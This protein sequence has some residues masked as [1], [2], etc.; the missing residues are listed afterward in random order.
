MTADPIAHPT[1]EDRTT[2]LI[3]FGAFEI[4]GGLGVLLMVA[5]LFFAATMASSLA[6]ETPGAPAAPFSPGMLLALTVIY[7]A[8][9]SVQI[10][11][12]VGSILCRRWARTLSLLL[13]WVG[14]ATGCFATIAMLMLWPQMKQS[15]TGATADAGAPE[16]SGLIL[17]VPLAFVVLLMV[18]APAAFVLFYRR[19]DVRATC[20]RKDP[21]PRW[22]DSRPLPILALT[23]MLAWGVLTPLNLLMSGGAFILFGVLFRG[24][25]ALLVAIAIAA[26]CIWCARRIW[27]LDVRGWW[28]ALAVW[29]GLGVSG[30]LSLRADNQRL[31]FEEMGLPPEQIEL[32]AEHGLPTNAMAPLMALSVLAFL[33]FFLYSKQFFAVPAETSD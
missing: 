7:L 22:T 23:L 25:S 5:F 29:L 31:L 4:L 12:G 33:I 32:I 26:A 10:S 21:K 2:G 15:M 16:I 9:A 6:P 3:V 14:L 13:A 30:I 17:L 20:E 24:V 18:L 28:T 1:S 11:L 19:A 8:V 27:A